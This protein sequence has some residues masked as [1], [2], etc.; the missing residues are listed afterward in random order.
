[1]LEP[2]E[3]PSEASVLGLVQVATRPHR[4]RA[5]PNN[6]CRKSQG[7]GLAGESNP[8]EGSIGQLCEGRTQLRGWAPGDSLGLDGEKGQGRSAPGLGK[9]PGKG[10]CQKTCSVKYAHT[11]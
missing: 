1:M 9:G 2:Q 4:P 8:G 11:R 7:A 10:E 3:A 6:R 5:R